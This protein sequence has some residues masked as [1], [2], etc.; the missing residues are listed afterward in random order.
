MMLIEKIVG[1]LAGWWAVSF[2]LWLVGLYP[3]S[4]DFVMLPF[5]ILIF[6]LFVSLFVEDV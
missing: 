4:F 2:L 5:W 3:L 1:W 6:A